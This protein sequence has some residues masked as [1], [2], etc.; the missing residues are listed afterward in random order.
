LNFFRGNKVISFSLMITSRTW[1]WMQS[2]SWEKACNLDVLANMWATRFVCLLDKLTLEFRT[3]ISKLLQ[4]VK[5]EL[6]PE[7]PFLLL[8]R[9][10]VNIFAI[11]LIDHII[12]TQCMSSFN[13][14]L[15]SKSL[16]SCWNLNA[17]KQFECAFIKEPCSSWR[18]H[19][20]IERQLLFKNSCIEIA[21]YKTRRKRNPCSDPILYNAT[22]HGCWLRFDQTPLWEKFH[23]K[24][25]FCMRVWINVFPDHLVSASPNAL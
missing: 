21:F 11:C 22:C 2:K 14:F 19:A 4:C 9:K 5:I 23:G 1:E 7:T 15:K 10:S 6:K 8:C 3:S 18:P 12:Y 20:H 24:C 16:C 17:K 13:A 25:H